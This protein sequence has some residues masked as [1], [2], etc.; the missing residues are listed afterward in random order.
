MNTIH[1]FNIQHLVGENK[2]AMSPEHK[3]L[4]V[5][6]HLSGIPTLYAIVDPDVP[7]TAEVTIR[8][9]LTGE[10]FDER[11]ENIGQFLGTVILGGGFVVHYFLVDYDV[12]I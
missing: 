9:I 10:D 4:N 5:A 7:K 11:D 8:G 3:L 2:I 6:M 12:S 1:R